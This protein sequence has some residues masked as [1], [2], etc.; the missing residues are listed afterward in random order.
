[1]E[2]FALVEN[3]L[4]AVSVFVGSEVAGGRVLAICLWRNDP[5]NVPHYEAATNSDPAIAF[6]CQKQPWPIDRHG[7]KCW[8][9]NK[10]RGFTARQGIA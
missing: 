2:L 9:S 1:M 10:I 7:Q 5:L 8:N 3:A 4:D 6:V